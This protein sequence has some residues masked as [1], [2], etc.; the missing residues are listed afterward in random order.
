MSQPSHGT[1]EAVLA[2]LDAIPTVESQ[3]F[4]LWMPQHLTLNGQAARPDIA[5]ALILDKILGMGYEPDGFSEAD[6]G[7]VY[8]YRVMT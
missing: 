2:H 5:M 6:G 8:R 4:E 1:V 3:S 7:K